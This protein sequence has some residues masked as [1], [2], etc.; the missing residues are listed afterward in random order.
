M[1]NIFRRFI[2]VDT[3]TF[4]DYPKELIQEVTY[5]DFN[6]TFK[7]ISLIFNKLKYLTYGDIS[8]EL[9][10]STTKKLSSILNS[11]KLLFKLNAEKVPNVPYNSSIYYI[12]KSQNKYQ[13][14]GR[15]L[16]LY[17]FDKSLVQKMSL[18]TYCSSSYLF[19][20]LRTKRGSGYTV[21][22][23]IGTISNKYYLMFYVL[24]KVYS[25]E[26]MDRLLNEAIKE[27]FSLK[28]C[29]IDLILTH[30]N[31]R[32]NIKGYI[33]DKFNNLVNYISSQNY[34]LNEKIEENQESITYESI[35]KDIQEVFVTKVR[36]YAILSHRGNEIEEDYNREVNELDK[37][38]YFNNE[39]SN[40]I[41][42]DITYLNKY[43][44][45]SLI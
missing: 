30:L 11:P 25:P 33:E 12:F 2:T 21:Q 44:N 9:A 3:F 36:R 18:Y 13:V 14:Q 45:D 40:N 38:Y 31:N 43:V 8:Y 41:T 42:H 34:S 10:I 17:E 28:E 32:N 16:V 39:I 35:I 6:Y 15:T 23:S 26:K 19:D 5:N 7:N 37:V 20:Y 1:I 24:G 27:S 22:A 29:K 4:I